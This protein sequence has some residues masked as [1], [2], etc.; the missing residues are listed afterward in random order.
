MEDLEKQLQQLRER[1]EQLERQ[2]VRLYL[3]R[4][5]YDRDTVGYLERKVEQGQ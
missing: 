4:P 5:A 1:V 2:Q 3:K